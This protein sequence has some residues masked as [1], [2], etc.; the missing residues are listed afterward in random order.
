MPPPAPVTKYSTLSAINLV[1]PVNERVLIAHLDIFGY[2]QAHA[3]L[4]RI[5]ITMASP[6][7]LLP[8]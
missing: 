5:I 2:T 1:L 4:R 6:I 3:D 8:P 7:P